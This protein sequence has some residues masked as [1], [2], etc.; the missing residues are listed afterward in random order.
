[1]LFAALAFLAVFAT[2]DTSEHFRTWRT[3]KTWTEGQK[4]TA[5]AQDAHSLFAVIAAAMLC[6]T[7]I[8]VLSVTGALALGISVAL[9]N[10]RRLSCAR[11]TGFF[12]RGLWLALFF[13]DDYLQNTGWHK[14]C[15]QGASVRLQPFAATANHNFSHRLYRGICFLGFPFSAD[16][17]C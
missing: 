16:A 5:S 14:A 13:C 1:V 8:V 7:A 6:N 10:R 12:R 17:Y 2:I 11:V 9:D 3:A 4:V 15:A